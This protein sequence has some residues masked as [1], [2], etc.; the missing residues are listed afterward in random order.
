M[1]SKSRREFIIS[2]GA[3]AASAAMP[4]LAASEERELVV[5]TAYPDEVV[6]R[7]ESLFGKAYPQYRLK[8]IWRMPFD[9]VPY[10][11]KQG[12]VD[13]YWSASP[14]A[15]YRLKAKGAWRRIGID[16][17]GLPGRI[18]N[19][20]IDDPDGYFVATEVAA[21]GF[22]VNPAYLEK[23]ELPV[24]KDW[25][26]LA[27][28]RYFGHVVMPTPSLVG[29]APVMVDIPL[30][31]FGWER[32]WAMWSAIAANSGFVGTKGAFITDEVDSNKYGVGL[33]IDF[34]AASKIANGSSMKFI[35]P[36]HGGVNPGQVAIAS[37][38]RNPEGA[39]AFV[40]LLLSEKGQTILADPDIRKLPVRPSVYSGL[41]GNYY[42]PFAAAEK[43]GYAYD[44]DMGRPRLALLAAAFEQG[45]IRSRDER[46]ML[47][48]ELNQLGT[49]AKDEAF[50]LFT[51]P[52]VSDEE[53]AD[54]ALQ[55]AFSARGENAQLEALAA[56]AE[57]KWADQALVRLE[58]VRRLVKA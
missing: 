25:G 27:D 41:A 36:E 30:Q 45:F 11:E 49:G 2:L 31:Y 34:F 1:E 54:P 13:V 20:L 9:A 37:G 48:R 29:F 6:A 28:P 57:R 53:A 12:G 42:N 55:H 23:H 3:V 19:T 47:W 5:L 51:A 50:R 16:R 8:I 18:G 56:Q 33:T 10:L 17:S 24:P 35:Y 40:S 26:D 46:A 7:Y 44:N 4:A 52:P 43:G 38:C 32:G 39:K 15:Y 21:Y 58:K 22:L 14:P